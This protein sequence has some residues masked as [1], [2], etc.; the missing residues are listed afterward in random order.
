MTLQRYE[1]IFNAPN[2]LSIFHN[3][4]HPTGDIILVGGEYFVV[5]GINRYFGVFCNC[6]YGVWRQSA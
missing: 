6:G 1:N 2:E 3:S 4:F 5:A